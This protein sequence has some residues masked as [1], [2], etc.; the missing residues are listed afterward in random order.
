MSFLQLSLVVIND[1][2]D[3]DRW[4]ELSAVEAVGSLQHIVT[5]LPPLQQSGCVCRGGRTLARATSH[6]QTPPGC[7]ARP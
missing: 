2:D 6:G 4:E 1:G 5:A 3:G 7:N